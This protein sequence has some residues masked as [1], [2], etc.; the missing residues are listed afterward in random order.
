MKPIR[1]IAKSIVKRGVK[2][3]ADQAYRA[4]RRAPELIQGAGS[5]QFTNLR[6]Y[7]HELVNSNPN[8][9]VVLQCFDSSSDPAFERIYVCL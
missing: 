4:K 7:A 9:N 6:S 3:S 5:D 8:N 2:L 1:F